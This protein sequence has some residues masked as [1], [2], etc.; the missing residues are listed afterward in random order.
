MVKVTSGGI[1]SAFSKSISCLVI[2]NIFAIPWPAIRTESLRL[3]TWKEPHP[4]AVRPFA[5]QPVFAQH[6][7]DVKVLTLPLYWKAECDA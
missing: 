1:A 4:S 3:R 6:R 7:L 5:T 2:P